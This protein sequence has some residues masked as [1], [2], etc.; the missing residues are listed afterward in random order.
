M[1]DDQLA[2]VAEGTYLYCEKSANNKI[3]RLLYSGI[4]KRPHIK[5]FIVCTT[6]GYI[7]NAFDPYPAVDNDVKILTNILKTLVDFVIY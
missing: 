5:P 4:K 3:Q 7:I 2:L 1:K 6:T